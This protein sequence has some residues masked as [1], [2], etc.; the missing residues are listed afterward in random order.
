MR[1]LCVCHAGTV[2]SGAMAFYLKHCGH[3]ALALSSKYNS[4][5]TKHLLYEWAEKILV[6][7]YTLIFTIPQEYQLKVINTNVGNDVWQNPLHP[8][9]LETCG[10]IYYQIRE[11]LSV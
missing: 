4:E 8:D 3:D 10:K 11:R 9:L 6:M 5:E 2:R 1:I 7:D